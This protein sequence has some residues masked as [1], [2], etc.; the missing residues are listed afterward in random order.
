MTK[1]IERLDVC[2]DKAHGGRRC[3]STPEAR[4]R[5]N[6]RR[7]AKYAERIRKNV[8]SNL[9]AR[10]TN[11]VSPGN[12]IRANERRTEE[13]VRSEL[14]RR[15]YSHGSGD[16]Q[17]IT[18]NGQE[19]TPV[20][21]QQVPEHRLEAFDIDGVSHPSLY[22]LSSADAPLFT[23][24]MHKL[25]DPQANKFFASVYVYSVEEYAHMRLFVTDDGEAGFA[26]KED[27][28]IVSVYSTQQSRHPRV[29]RAMIATAVSMGGKKL[30]C[31]DTVL[32]K[33]YAAEGFVETGR[34]S[35]NDE[36][37]PEGWDYETYTRYNEG[38]PDV[39]YMEY[40]KDSLDGVYPWESR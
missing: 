12:G 11:S 16:A 5:I 1:R 13:A 3:G 14:D 21:I 18:V 36:Y 4:T 2:R 26:L 39:V 10:S 30:D 40:N 27:G 17:R 8:G 37:K 15:G 20:S 7:R 19:I 6:A 23:E 35:W 25:A 22:E 28:D 31:F 38:R 9:D 32:P 33:I 34:D 29:A 24:K